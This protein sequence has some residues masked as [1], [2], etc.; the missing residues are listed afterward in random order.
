[1]NSTQ[2]Q[3]TNGTNL[4]LDETAMKEGQLQDQG[5]LSFFFSFPFSIFVDPKFYKKIKYQK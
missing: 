2:L 1:L 5:I 3:L 4:I